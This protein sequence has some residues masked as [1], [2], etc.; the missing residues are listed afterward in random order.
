MTSQ[1][2][3]LPSQAKRS[4]PSGGSGRRPAPAGIGSRATSSVPGQGAQGLCQRA[5]PGVACS[6][7]ARGPRPQVLGQRPCIAWGRLLLHVSTPAH[8]VSKRTADRY[9][10]SESVPL[11]TQAVTQVSRAPLQSQYSMVITTRLLVSRHPSQYP[12]A[13]SAPRAVSWGPEASGPPTFKPSRATSVP[14]SGPPDPQPSETQRARGGHPTP[15]V[16][17][18]RPA[19]GQAPSTAPQRLPG[20]QSRP[21]PAPPPLGAAA[22][23]NTCVFQ[24]YPDGF[25]VST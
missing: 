21:R 25:E 5:R 3:R 8:A 20:C 19:L 9:V 17:G 11:G 16:A 12:K 14:A 10:P 4:D 15:S 2:Y 1:V 22:L 23:A 13:V 24:T 7:A 6:G 18:L